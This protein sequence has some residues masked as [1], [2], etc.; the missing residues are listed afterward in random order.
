MFPCISDDAGNEY[1]LSGLSRVRK[2]WTAVDT[3]A[4]GRKRTFYLSVCNPL[5]YIPGCHGELRAFGFSSASLPPAPGP[6]RA[7]GSCRQRSGVLPGVRRQQLEPG[8]GADQPPG[9]GEWVP[10]YRLRQRRQ[11]REPAL[12]HEDHARVR[13]DL[14]A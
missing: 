5:P 2:P 8:R 9:C 4:D 7:P 11:V 14:G 1:D 6:S 12:L 3:S 10:E 13:S